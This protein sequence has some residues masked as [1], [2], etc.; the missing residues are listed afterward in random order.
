MTPGPSVGQYE[1]TVRDV[2]VDG[3]WSIS[4]YNAE[5]YFEPNS[6]GM[7]SVTGVRNDDDSLT[8][9][10]GD[11]GNLANSIPITEGWDYLVRLYGPARRSS[12]VVG[13]SL[14][15]PRRSSGAGIAD[16]IVGGLRPVRDG[17]FAIS[18]SASDGV[19]AF[20]GCECGEV[21][22]EVVESAFD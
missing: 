11:H 21:G 14:P 20:F 17:A 16:V 22:E 13:V 5:G 1:L 4:V 15:S 12:T 18:C 9:R 2:P 10:F 19:S 3:L 6:A 8:V 7:Y